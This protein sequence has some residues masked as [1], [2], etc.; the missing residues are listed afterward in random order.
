MRQTLISKRASESSP[1]PLVRIPSTTIH[2]LSISLIRFRTGIGRRRNTH[3]FDYRWYTWVWRSDWQWGKVRHLIELQS[4]I[5]TNQLQALVKLL[6]ILSAST[7]TFLL[8]SLVS[9]VTPGSATIV[10]TL[11]C[12][13]LLLP[14]M[15]ELSSFH[16][17]APRLTCYKSPWIGYR[18]Y[19]TP[20]TSC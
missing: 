13:S 6:A 11:F 15:G 3:F 4:C 20:L 2:G 19:E 12:T 7:M 5:V 8:K 9:S 10:C 14:A 18:T 16:C 1:S 17:L